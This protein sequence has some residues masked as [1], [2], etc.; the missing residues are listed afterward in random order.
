MPDLVSQLTA[1]GHRVVL[2]APEDQRPAPDEGLEFA[3]VA[4]A[5]L[6]GSQAR[7]LSLAWS[8][9]RALPALDREHHFDL[10]HFT[11]APV[12]V[13]Q[14]GLPNG[15]KRER[16][17]RGRG[18]RAVV[19]PRALLGLALAMALLHR[20]EAGRGGGIAEA[21][22]VMANSRYPRASSPGS[23]GCVLIGSAYAI[24][25]SIPS[26]SRRL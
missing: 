14:T 2:L 6:A 7:W 5:R 4:P 3:G 11:D 23:T 21:L 1:D 26:G 24:R 13:L 9:S 16:H 12:L 8:L 15:W 25:L 18:R 20:G 19:L 10:I 17:L 22:S